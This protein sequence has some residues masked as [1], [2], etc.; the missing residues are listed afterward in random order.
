MLP[1]CFDLSDVMIS[2]P[3]RVK[4]IGEGEKREGEKRWVKNVQSG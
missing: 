3:Q 2:V 1:Y 4:G